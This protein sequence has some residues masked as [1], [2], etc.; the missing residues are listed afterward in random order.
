MS[1]GWSH[2]PAAY[3]AALRNLERKPRRWLEVCYAEIVADETEEIA[4]R[5]EDEDFDWSEEYERA[6]KVV[7]SRKDP[8]DSGT[9]VT[10]I[11]NFMERYRTCDNGGFNAYCC[12]SGCHKVSFTD[13]E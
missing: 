12:H 5:I 7:R 6:L 13:R 4:K 2:T 1:W 9:L 3:E 10:A 8:V 11:W